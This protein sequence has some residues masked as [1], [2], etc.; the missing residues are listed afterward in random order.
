MARDEVSS[1]NALTTWLIEKSLAGAGEADIVGGFCERLVHAGMPL[2]RAIVLVDTL[3]PIYEGRAFRWSRGNRQAE[4]LEY[5]RTRDGP[6]AEAWRRSP[7]Y[8]MVETNQSILRRR[9]TDPFPSPETPDFATF[10]E[11]R[12]EGMTDFVALV[13]RFA[14]AG[15][16][17]EMDA[18]YSYW[19]SDVVCGFDESHIAMLQALIKPLAAAL[20][21]ASLARIAA[22]LVETYLGRDAGRRVLSGRIERG[23]A[24]Q[25]SA[26]LWYSDLR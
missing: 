19:T 9:L 12:N 20:K 17:G 26:V 18:I 3:H 5:G 13:T 7:L 6:N 23:V 11:L 21:C 25:I 16:I 24:E 4:V 2:A 22:T 1:P 15:V 14:P 10:G 8:Y